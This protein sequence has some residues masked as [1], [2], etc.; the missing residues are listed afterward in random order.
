M[1]KQDT[2]DE[3]HDEEVNPNGSWFRLLIVPHHGLSDALIT[4][5]HPTAF[6]GRGGVKNEV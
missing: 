5:T 3:K 1:K 4:E 2:Y 6:T